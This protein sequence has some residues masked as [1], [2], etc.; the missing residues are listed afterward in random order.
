[1]RPFARWTSLIFLC[2][3]CGVEGGLPLDDSGPDVGAIDAAVD[4]DVGFDGGLNP[5]AGQDGGVPDG[6][7]PDDSGPTVLIP[8]GPA[9]EGTIDPPGEVD[10]YHFD[11]RPGQFIWITAERRFSE[12]DPVLELYDP[13]GQR[14]AAVDDLSPD[15]FNRRDAEIIYRLTRPGRYVILVH[16]WRNW[17][18]DPRSPVGGPTFEYRLTL[19]WLDDT[20]DLETLAPETGDLLSDALP[21]FTATGAVMLIGS[22]FDHPNDVDVYRFDLPTW[23]VFR[24]DL[25][26]MGVPG[27]GGTST[28]ARM[29]IT[30]TAGVEVVAP[31]NELSGLRVPLEPGPYFFWIEHSGAALGANPFYALKFLAE[32]F[33]GSYREPRP[34][35]NDDINDPGLFQLRDGGPTQIFGTLPP[36][37]TDYF[38][39]VGPNFRGGGLSCLSKSWGSGVDGLTITLYD[40]Q[41]QPMDSD[42]ETFDTAAFLLPPGSYYEGYVIGITRGAQ[43]PDNPSVF[44]ACEI[45]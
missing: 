21:I 38:A 37:D 36:G 13:T 30:S 5:D 17:S 32:R 15:S 2:A 34:N 16:D 7:S 39:V 8:G 1:M 29:V 18:E 3:A 31:L 11:G 43:L 22:G 40:G 4:P 26:P 20:A 41:L 24:G 42:T 28:A 44:Y 35:D 9:L 25:M 19:R 10:E 27:Y 12:L 14:V 6:A 45:L 33:S 23:A